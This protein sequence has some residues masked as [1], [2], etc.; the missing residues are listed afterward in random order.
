MKKFRFL[1]SLVFAVLVLVSGMRS[2]SAVEFRCEGEYPQ[3]LQGFASDGESVFWSFTSVLVKTDLNGKRLQ[4]ID[5]PSHHGDCC[6]VDGK[7]YVATHLNWPAEDRSAWIYI[8]DCRDLTLLEKINVP[9]LDGAGLDGI[10]FFDGHFY[11]CCGKDSED[12]VPFNRVFKMTKDFQTVARLQVPGL[13]VYGIQAFSWGNG[14]FWLGTYGK[15]GTIQCDADLKV[16]GKHK[17]DAS[18]GVYE[19]PP[20]ENG[21]PRLMIATHRRENGEANRNWALARS[22]VLKDGQLVWEDQAKQ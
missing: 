18:V 19:L 2:V 11:V 14:S 22:A 8:Y 16:V 21:E 3:H 20:S 12:V 7:L 13:T 1:S 10:S 17:I 5:V 9:E 4:Q 15:E 6:V